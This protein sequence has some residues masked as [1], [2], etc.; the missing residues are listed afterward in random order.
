MYLIGYFG[1]PFLISFLIIHF[2]YRK[3]YL[4]KHN[5]ALGACKEA[6]WIIGLGI[7]LAVIAF[8]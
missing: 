7:L 6:L 2:I 4:K 1:M 5:K 8:T 3:R